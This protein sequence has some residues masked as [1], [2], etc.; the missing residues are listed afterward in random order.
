MM[1]IE[2]TS[3]RVLT[4]I[5]VTLVLVGFACL[6]YVA[7]TSLA[8][9]SASDSNAGA[10][11]A[12]GHHHQQADPWYCTCYTTDED[13]DDSSEEL[14][15]PTTE[16]NVGPLVVPESFTKPPQSLIDKINDNTHDDHDDRVLIVAASNYGMRDHVYNWIESLKRTGE[17]DKFLV[18]CLDQQ[19]YEHM[20]LAGYEKHATTLPSNWFHSEIEAGF[21]EYYSKKYRI[22]THAKTLIVQQL[23]YL[24]I[25]VLFSDVD[26][27]WLRPRIRD[28]VCTFLE[29]REQTH[30]VFQQ[31]GTDQ[32]VVNSGFYAMRPSDVT[33]RLLAETIHLGDTD[34]AMTQQGAM[35]AA[36]DNID[37]NLRTTSLVLLDVL[38]FPNGYVYFDN[39]WPDK[40][41]IEPFIVHAN[42]LVTF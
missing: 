11:A 5:G 33:K 14:D 29:M 40:H 26:I 15:T 9:S 42:Y 39:D 16:R 34:E 6:K 10:A 18:F 21:E 7:T 19:M 37:L 8:L 12:S 35:N 31:E 36:M 23:L 27:V 32:K 17:G 41:G 3:R 30:M 13:Q 22:I 25:T 2:R 4:L 24:D 1:A 20:V 28:Y 38:H